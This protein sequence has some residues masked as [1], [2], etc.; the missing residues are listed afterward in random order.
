MAKLIADRMLY[1]LWDLNLDIGYSVR[2]EAQCIEE[3]RDVTVRTSLLDGRLIAGSQDLFD[4]F[5]KNIISYCMNHNTQ[6]FIQAKLDENAVR[7]KK[8]GSSVYLLEPNLK[9][10]EGGLRDLQ[11]ALWISRVKFKSRN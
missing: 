9:E 10:G 1:L 6:L 7:K 2:S 11:S 5:D 3:A 4:N 8:Y